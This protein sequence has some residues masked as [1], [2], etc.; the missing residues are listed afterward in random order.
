[1]GPN[2]LPGL[3]SLCSVNEGC[4]SRSQAAIDT[5]TTHYEQLLESLRQQTQERNVNLQPHVLVG[6]P[7]DQLLKAALMVRVR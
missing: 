5:A 2:A 4:G 6:H 3:R 1:M 7:A